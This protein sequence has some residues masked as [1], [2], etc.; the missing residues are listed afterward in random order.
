MNEEYIQEIQ[1]YK[2]CY[3]NYFKTIYYQII[4]LI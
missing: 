2:K 3:E 4:F 1:S